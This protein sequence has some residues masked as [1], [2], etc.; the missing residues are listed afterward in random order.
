MSVRVIARPYKRE[1]GKTTTAKNKS[2]DEEG[3]VNFVWRS[4][5][6][7]FQN[8]VSGKAYLMV[9]SDFVCTNKDTQIHTYSH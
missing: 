1:I 2:E 5:P 6:A 8:T 7:N 3:I 4:N 9:C